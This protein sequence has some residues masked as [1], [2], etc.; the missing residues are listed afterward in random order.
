MIKRLFLLLTATLTLTLVHARQI[1]KQEAQ[2]KAEQ[3]LDKLTQSSSNRRKAPR[4]APKLIPASN[5]EEL[6]VFND[7]ANGGYVIVSGDDC[8]PSILGY[9]ETGV[10]DNNMPDNMRAWLQEY[11]HQISYLKRNPDTKVRK[12]VSGLS[13]SPLLGETSWGQQA[14]YNLMCPEYEGN[15]TL[16]GCVSTAMAQIM[17]YYRWPDATTKE[18]PGYTTETLKLAVNSIP[19][20]NID[21][22]N[23]L[24]TYNSGSESPAQKEAVARLMLMCGTALNMDYMVD[25]SS[26]SLD[27]VSFALK[28]YFDYAKNLKVIRQWSY[29]LD[30]WNQII[31]N[32]LAA[33]RPVCY[34]GENA[35]SE[36]HA[37][38]VDGY[39]KGDYF[40]VSWGWNGANDGYFLLSLLDPNNIGEGYNGYQAAIIG[41]KRSIDLNPEGYN[42][43]DLI[44]AKT[45]EGVEMTFEIISVEDKTCEVRGNDDYKPAIDPRTSGTVTIPEEVNGYKVT[46]IGWAAFYGCG[47]LQKVIMPQTVTKIGPDAFFDC[48]KLESAEIPS[49]VKSID[50]QAFMYCESLTSFVIPDGVTEIP[51]NTFTATNFTSVIPPGYESRGKYVVIPE[52][53]TRIIGAAFTGCDSL[54]SVILP[55]GVKEVGGNMACASFGN[56]FPSCNSLKDLRVE[57]GSPYYHAEGNCIIETATNCVSIGCNYSV[58]PSYAKHIGTMAFCGLAFTSF[59]VPEGIISIGESAFQSRILKEV[60]LPSTIT[61]LNN[62]VF[63]NCRSLTTL[64]VKMKTPIAIGDIFTLNALENLYVPVGTKALYET[65]DGWKNFKNI[66]EMDLKPILENKVFDFRNSFDN[67]ANKYLGGEIINNL[68]FNI[69]DSYR[70]YLDS[71]WGLQIFTPSDSINNESRIEDLFDEDFREKFTGIVFKV[72]AGKGNINITS[73]TMG[74]MMLAVKIGSNP[75]TI[76]KTNDEQISFPYEVN[77]GTNVYIYGCSGTEQISD[78]RQVRIYQIGIN[79]TSINKYKIRYYDGDKLIAEDEV[80]YGAEVVLRD[81]TPE[82]AARYTFLGWVGLTYATMPAHDIEYHAN[83]A[84]GVS[85]LERVPDGVEAIYDAN[86]RKIRKLQRGVDVVVMSDGTKKK[87]VVK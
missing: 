81:Y 16:T 83:I 11:A 15:H 18:I 32:E 12:S 22:N 39:D 34:R 58:I 23:I 86:G 82:D 60:T 68:Y 3:F 78:S 67:Y 29:S 8:V 46:S 80:E 13:I 77:D 45:A 47:E 44:V 49:G 50:Y 75:P 85:R 27:N 24:P 54:E 71:W 26:S 87:V 6:Y 33:G 7:E 30:D 25:A 48:R 56:P 74:N 36:G 21:W 19:V 38:V 40:H 42:D 72:P 41:I 69:P 28:E 10:I 76:I 63:Y 52:S 64:R 35:D 70:G 1:S 43:G 17:N 14:P 55:A 73:A 2:Q 5:Y 51:Y 9:S 53:V 79:I 59:V 62:D 20:S 66:I 4:K 65:A 84:D 31:Y 57:E 37:F 61:S